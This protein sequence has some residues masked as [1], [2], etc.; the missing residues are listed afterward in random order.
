MTTRCQKQDRAETG[1]GMVL[2]LMSGGGRGNTVRSKASWVMV[3]RGP[4]VGTE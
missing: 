1:T 4:P 3:T 2:G